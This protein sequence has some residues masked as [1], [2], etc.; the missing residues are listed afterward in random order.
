MPHSRG[1]ES[2]GH[3]FAK[4]SR[5]KKLINQSPLDAP[6]QGTKSPAPLYY[7][8]TKQF[9]KE[10]SQQFNDFLD[11]YKKAYQGL[12]NGLFWLVFPEGSIPP[13]AEATG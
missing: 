13:N 6:K 4:V 5:T 10:P 3:F 11:A 12:A 1:F 9:R 2:I 8:S 7:A